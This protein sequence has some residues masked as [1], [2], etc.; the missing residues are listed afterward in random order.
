METPSYYSVLTAEVRYSKNI[1]ANEKLLFAEITSLSNT[2]GI[3]WASNAYFSSLFDCTSQAISKWIKNLERNGFI[4]ITYTYKNGSKEIERREII[5][6][7]NGIKGINSRLGGYQHTIKDNNTSINNKN[8]IERF[9]KI[10][11]YYDIK[12]DKGLKSKA[13]SAYKKNKLNKVSSEDI[14]KVLDFERNKTYGQRHLSTIFNNFHEI[15][16]SCNK[17]NLKEIESFEM[18]TH[19]L[20]ASSVFDKLSDTQ[21]KIFKDKGGIIL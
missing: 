11:T 17:T 5:C 2:S 12:T 6:I 10:W 18:P 1:N 15:L 21:K 9:E 8:I 7:N 20:M 13:L 4:T 14:M 19:G 16:E 3:C